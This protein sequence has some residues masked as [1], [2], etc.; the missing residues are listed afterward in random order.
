MTMIP[1][2]SSNIVAVAYDDVLRELTVEF[3]SGSLYA[4]LGVTPQQYD[5]FMAAPSKGSYLSRF[6]KPYHAARRVS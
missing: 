5:G 2:Q 1:V 3:M 6:I 4:Y